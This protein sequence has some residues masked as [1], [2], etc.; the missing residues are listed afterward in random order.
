MKFSAGRKWLFRLSALVLLPLL[1]LT[2]LELGLRL[3]GYGYPTNFFKRIR[4]GDKE[5]LVENDKFGWRFFPSE[6]SRSPAPVVMA[7]HKPAGTCRIFLFGE[8][9]ALGDPRPAYG[10]GRYL[11]TLLRERFPETKFE[12]VC[13]AMTA[14]DSHAI[15][16]IAR[17]CARYQG[18]FWIIYMG[19]N[20]MVG[21]FG[22]TA[23]FG[24][25]TPPLRMVRLS[26][27]MQRVRLGQLLLALG[28]KLQNRSARTGSWAGMKMFLENRI[29]PDD[30]HREIVCQNFQ[31]NLEDILRAGLDAGAKMILNTVAVNLKDCPPFAS[32]PVTNLTA[33]DRAAYDKFWAD[34]ALAE[35]QGQW[36]RAGEDY[37]QAARLAPQSADLQ[38]RLGE[39]LLRLSNAPA[40]RPHFELARDLDALPFRTS[41][42]LSGLTKQV[43]EQLAGRG[44]VVYDAVALFATNSPVGIPGQE[45]FYEHA[46]CNFD[47]NYRL[48]RAWAEQVASR[49]GGLPQ[50]VTNHAGSDWA[51]QELC[52][53]RLGLSDWNRASVLEDVLRR[54]GEPPLS[55]QGTAAWREQRLERFRAW[56]RDLRGRMDAAAAGPARA[57]YLEAL[58]RAPDDHRLHE[59]FAEFLEAV[60]DLQAA[61]AR[62]QR[63]RQLIPQHHLAYFQAG[64]L[65]ARQG[66]LPEAQGLLRQA[67]RLRPDLGEG[68]L[69]L[70]RIDAAQAKPAQA[71]TEY[72]RARR[73]TPQ[74]YRVRYFMGKALSQLGRR[75]EAE[76]QYRQALQLRANYWEARYAL[77]EELAFDGKIAEAR[78]ELE[79]VLRLKPDYPPAHFNLGVALLK[80]G[81]VEDAVKQ[82]EETLRL[83][84]QNKLAADALAQAR[85]KQERKP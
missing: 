73:L 40:A 10:A 25:P 5:L 47:G 64:R 69:E 23:V 82:F 66:K 68:W 22:A 53:R 13:V 18:D 33:A 1:L 8:S 54:L 72:E 75:A 14:I 76:A 7:A 26:L 6:L 44:V 58:A 60:G 29:A 39:C 74:D 21:P 12:V 77:G 62:W 57:L 27:A 56:L 4:I 16:P 24:P 65:L 32:V 28:R 80:L 2:G 9:A 51:T 38:F 71:L 43:G 59:N 42:R 81:Q 3:G 11:Q 52:E 31:R 85:A 83:E 36:S 34:A 20:E 79:E 48:A 49:L 55:T 46:H 70:G 19:N 50:A 61:T 67:V 35:E 45:S 37:Q 15:L 41:S 63:V 84:P 78:T 17:E 30:P